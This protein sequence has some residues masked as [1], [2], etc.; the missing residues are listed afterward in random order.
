MIVAANREA[1]INVFLLGKESSVVDTAVVDTSA[2]ESE[3]VE[4]EEEVDDKCSAVVCVVST[5]LAR[6]EEG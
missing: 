4:C 2:R 3:V 1:H 6:Q 5:A